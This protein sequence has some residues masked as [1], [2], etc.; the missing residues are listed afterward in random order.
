MQNALVIL[1][2]FVFLRIVW[3]QFAE[4]VKV[5]LDNLSFGVTDQREQHDSFVD[6]IL[7][8]FKF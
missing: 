7:E 4:I 8:F 2:M 6:L 3:R 5:T 1:K